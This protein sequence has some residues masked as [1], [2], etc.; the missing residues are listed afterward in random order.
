M[1]L[2]RLR[3]FRCG[4]KFKWGTDVFR[5]SNNCPICEICLREFLS[6]TWDYE[7]ADYIFNEIKKNHNHKYNKWNKWFH[8]NNELCEGDHEDYAFYYEEKEHITIIDG[9]KC[10]RACIDKM[11]DKLL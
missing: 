2:Y 3:C 6:E 7:Y 10:C 8:K 11:N 9:K 4:K 5:D 1:K